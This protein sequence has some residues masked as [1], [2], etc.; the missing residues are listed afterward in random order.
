MRTS[1]A[2]MAALV[3]LTDPDEEFVVPADLAAE[4]M[5]GRPARTFNH[6]APPRAPAAPRTPQQGS[7]PA[8]STA[9]IEELDDIYIKARAFAIRRNGTRPVGGHAGP[10][11][12][13][14][15]AGFAPAAGRPAPPPMASAPDVD[16]AELDQIYRQAAAWGARRNGQKGGSGPHSTPLAAVGR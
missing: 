1:L 10:P 13:H 6:F 16:A 9:T 2:K 15:P 14:A 7:S 5:G 8:M 11:P 3:G 12:G 4:L